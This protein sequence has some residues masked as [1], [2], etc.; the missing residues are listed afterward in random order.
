MEHLRLPIKRADAVA[1]RTRILEAALVVFAARGLDMEVG[2]IVARADLAIGTLYR[3]FANRDDLLRAIVTH[4]L[5]DT[6]AQ[7]RT[8]VAET[9]DDPCASLLTFFSVGLRVQQ[10]YGP[11]FAVIRDPRLRN[12][13]DPTQTQTMRDQ[14]L[15]VVLG[16]LSTGINASI[17]R[18]DLDREIVAATI[19]GSIMGVSDLFVSRWSSQELA[20]KLFH[21]HLAM[22]TSKETS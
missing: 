11:I 22:L 10:Q 9:I 3:H 20:Q 12:I 21:L 17:F 18:D 1:N 8:A 19:M 14:F 13:F 4:V 7:F 5:N 16:I 15:E 2:E 6:L